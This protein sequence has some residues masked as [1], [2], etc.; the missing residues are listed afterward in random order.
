MFYQKILNESSPYVTIVSKGNSGFP[1]H[2]HYEIEMHYCKSGSMRLTIG[3]KEHQLSEGQLVVISVMTPHA[4]ISKSKHT[5]SM[6]IEIGPTFLKELF[7]FLGTID[8]ENPIISL[9]NDEEATHLLSLL[10]KLYELATKN[11]P[12]TKL[13][14]NGLLWN[15]C[16]HISKIKGVDSNYKSKKRDQKIERILDYIHIHYTEDLKL[17]NIVA[18]MGYSKGNICKTFKEAVGTSFHNYLNNYRIQNSLYLLKNT[19]M[20]IGEIAES[21]GF[22]E[23]KTFCRVFKSVI[24]T[25]PSEFRK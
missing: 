19:D 6:L 16:Y 20:P 7:V 25:T 17:D 18:L 14:K 4:I 11:D 1:L 15:I 3:E 23:F 22:S 13:L 9:Y 12:Q 5:E 21:V 8:L 24:G 10:D 2:K